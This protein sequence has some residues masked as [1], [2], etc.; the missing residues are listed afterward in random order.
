MKHIYKSFFLLIFI[1]SNAHSDEWQRV[2]L[3]SFMRS[4]NHWMRFLIEEATH[5]ATG[6]VYKD[7][8]YFHLDEPFPWGFS[9]DKGYLGNCR[10]PDIDDIVVIKTHFPGA[11]KQPF[12]KQNFIKTIRIVRHPVDSCY[13]FFV[14]RL[15]KPYPFIVS[16]KAF[17]YF[18]IHWKKF[19]DY[20]NNQKNVY[21]IKYEDLL[22][23]PQEVL[24]KVL[25]EIGYHVNDEDIDR[26]LAIYPPKNYELQHLKH[27]ERKQ[28]DL[29]KREFKELLE[30]FG[31]IIP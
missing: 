18:L 2:Y 1:F 8:D 19:Q 26:A 23:N 10:Y 3:A 29:M 7:I 13:S 27:Y 15:P 5:I 14:H 30:Q 11:L 25:E 4:G 9:T 20:W 6:S 21:T 17:S 16:N 22:N 12:D 31:Y 28:L 24:K